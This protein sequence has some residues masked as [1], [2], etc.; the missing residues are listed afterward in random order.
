MLNR[1]NRQCCD[2]KLKHE[3]SVFVQNF[4]QLLLGDWLVDNLLHA[5]LLGSD[6]DLVICECSDGDY[7]T[8]SRL[9]F[10]GRKLLLHRGKPRVLGVRNAGAHVVAVPAGHLDVSQH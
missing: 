2:L 10:Y 5:H 9:E 4:G 7:R 6:L 3:S 8:G 1:A